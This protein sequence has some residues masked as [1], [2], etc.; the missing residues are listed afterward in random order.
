M[1]QKQE[2]MNNLSSQKLSL[3]RMIVVKF[4]TETV[5][6]QNNRQRNKRSNDEHLAIGQHKFSAENRDTTIFE[7][8]FC[9]P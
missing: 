2:T 4:N 1:N 6:Q 7:S 3:Q 5:A 8:F 9:E